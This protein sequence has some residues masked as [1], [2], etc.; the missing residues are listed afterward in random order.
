MEIQIPEKE[1][2]IQESDQV[3]KRRLKMKRFITGKKSHLI[4]SAGGLAIAVALLCG[5]VWA[6]K[7]SDQI[8]IQTDPPVQ[9]DPSGSDSTDSVNP[10]RDLFRLQQEMEQLFD[11]QQSLWSSFPWDRT[12]H[13]DAF[14]QQPDMD[15]HEKD[16][17]YQVKVDLPGVDKSAIHVDVKD[18]IL[19]VSAEEQQIKEEKEDGKVLMKERSVGYVRRSIALPKAVD[20]AGV[21]AEYKDGVLNITLPK[22]DKE[23]P[24]HRIEIR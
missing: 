1:S 9:Q 2:D 18:N 12:F 10:F 16:G 3:Q 14:F 15:L 22:L 4:V 5:A 13:E 17:V 6:E 11:D 19:T 8:D 23:E 7:K 24:S 21:T 20:S